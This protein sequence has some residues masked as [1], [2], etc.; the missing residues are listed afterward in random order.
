MYIYI[1][2]SMYTCVY[3]C[4]SRIQLGRPRHGGGGLSIVWGCMKRV[5]LFTSA[6]APRGQIVSCFW[7]RGTLS[8]SQIG[9][10]RLTAKPV[11]KTHIGIHSA[12]LMSRRG[13]KDH[14]ASNDTPT[15]R[16]RSGGPWYPHFL[17]RG[18]SLLTRPLNR[19]AEPIVIRELLHG[20]DE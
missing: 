11:P 7:C 15:I 19:W 16:H 8:R 3:I 17:I 1:Y 6:L 12:Y 14:C 2:D 9:L 18:R 4:I 10:A 5:H 20:V 13:R